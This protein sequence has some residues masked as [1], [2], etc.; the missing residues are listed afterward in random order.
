[1]RWLDRITNS[2]D[3]SVSKLWE[4]VKDREAWRAA[5]HGVAE[6]RTRLRTEQPLNVRSPLHVEHTLHEPWRLH[7]SLWSKVP[8]GA[9]EKRGGRVGAG[10]HGKQSCRRTVPD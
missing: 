10:P 8:S 9:K 6:S 3:M 7:W 4:I 1:M 2:M 5:A